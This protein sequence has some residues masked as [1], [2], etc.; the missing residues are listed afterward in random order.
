MTE[1]CRLRLLTV[2]VVS[3]ARMLRHSSS[4]FLRELGVATRE[5]GTGRGYQ[6]QDPANP[7]RKLRT[8]W[9]DYHFDGRRYRESSK[10][11]KKSDALA[12]LEAAGWVSTRSGRY[13]GA[14]ARRLTF[15]E[16]E[17]GIVAS[18]Q[19]NGHRSLGRLQA[20]FN[21]LREHFGGWK[22]SAISARALSSTPLNV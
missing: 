3:R 14:D 9:I 2:R 13:V 17:V 16:L 5:R 20:A 15:E 1:L 19:L 21:H 6:R 11:P 7:G 10:S 22:A 12:Q 4:T 8:W 18:Y